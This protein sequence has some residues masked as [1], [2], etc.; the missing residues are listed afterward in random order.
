MGSQRVLASLLEGFIESFDNLQS[1]FKL[2]GISW[3]FLRF[4]SESIWNPLES[5]R[6]SCETFRLEDSLIRARGIF[7]SLENLLWILFNMSCESYG[8]FRESSRFYKIHWNFLRILNEGI[9]N[10]L[11]SLGISYKSLRI[12]KNLRGILEILNSKTHRIR[13]VPS[14]AWK[15][16]SPTTLKE[17][18]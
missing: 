18:R 14:G 6:L 11:E 17:K 8:I 9:W 5:L 1:F 3:N 10:P 2:I 15:L 13:K 16:K 4:L 12:L 7:D